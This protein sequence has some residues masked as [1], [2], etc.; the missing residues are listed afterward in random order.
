[1]LVTGGE[2]VGYAAA[3]TPTPVL[4]QSAVIQRVG[5]HVSFERPGSSHFTRLGGAATTI[6][7]GTTVDASRGTVQV[8]VAS[9]TPGNPVSALFYTGEFALSQDATTAI[10]TLTLNGPLQQCPPSGATGSSGTSNARLATAKSK[11]PAQR[12]LWG[13][14]GAGHFQTKGNYA[15]ATVL[16]TVWLTTDSCSSTVVSV[17]EGSVGVEDLVTSASQTV[18]TDQALTVQST[19]ATSVASFSGPTSP[20]TY[21]Q[22]I[23]ISA[24]SPSVTLGQD[25]TLTATG[26]AAGAGTAYIYENVGAP[27]SSTLAAE[28]SN[29][30]AFEFTSKT[31]SGAGP[32]HLSAYP[33]A[34]HKGKKYYCAYLTD[35]A[36]H[37]QVLVTVS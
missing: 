24:S 10:A 18:T 8:T 1:M 22:S 23:R 25:Y 12:S 35:P 20:P 6:P 11:R 36:A 28:R 30:V 31:L 5:G 21:G 32:F 26:T 17:A 14:G 29:S 4:A 19:G 9:S 7:F 16:G 13:D 37:A 27:C 15:A 3:A 33:L 2:A 34:Q